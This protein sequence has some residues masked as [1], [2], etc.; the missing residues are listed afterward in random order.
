[1]RE[2][3]TEATASKGFNSILHKSVH[4]T[5]TRVRDCLMNITMLSKEN[6]LNMFTDN[7]IEL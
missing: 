5:N 2:R 7:L 1:M 6:T 4:Y 3:I